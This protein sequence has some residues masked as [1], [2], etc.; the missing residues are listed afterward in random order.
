[1]N[2]T[3]VVFL[4]VLGGAIIRVLFG[5]RKAY[6][7]KRFRVDWMRVLIEL[8]SSM[9][10]GGFALYALVSVGM[11]RFALSPAAGAIA[12]LLGADLLNSLA[13]RVSQRTLSV[14][15][16]PKKSLHARPRREL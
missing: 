7:K 2:E 14:D 16:S 6:D 3:L 12:G 9:L 13:K 10:F 15:L 11:A 4:G 1:M 5:L 8:I